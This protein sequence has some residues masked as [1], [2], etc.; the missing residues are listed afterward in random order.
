MRVRARLFV[1][2][3]IGL[4]LASASVQPTFAQAPAPAPAAAAADQPGSDIS[5]D[6]AVRFGRL[7]NGMHY[8]LM[9][10]AA[11][12]G[13]TSVRMR[14]AA[15]SLHERD[16]QRGLAHFIEHLAL[17]ETRNV[18]E[19]E[20]I[21][22]LERAGLSFGADTNA[23]T[24]FEQ[25]VYMLDLPRTDAATVDTALFLMREAVG[26]ATLSP[27]VID[28]ERGVVLSEER[29][30]A[31]P[32]M[33]LAVDELSFLFGND[34]LAR[35]L[36]I[37]A[38]DIISSAQR[39]QFAHFYD[40]YYRPERATLVIVGDFEIDAMEAKIRQRFGDWRGRGAAGPELP[41]IQLGRR[42]VESRVFVEAGLPTRVSLTWAEPRT[43]E[44]DT[45]ATRREGYAA[46]IGMTVLNRR[47][48]RLASG[49]SPP[50]AAA[51]GQI[52]APGERV[53]MYQLIA[54][55]QPNGWRR[56][57]ETIEQEHRRA[58]EHGF[59]E[60]E[61][62][63]EIAVMRST[64]TNAAAGRAS[65]SS[66]TVAD[67]IVQSINSGTIVTSPAIDLALFNE[68]A[69]NLTPAEINAEFRKGFASSNPV[70]HLAA[71]QPVEN[72]QAVLLSAYEA[73]RQLA[74]TPPAV[75]QAQAWPYESFGTA[76]TVAERRELT[77]IGATA[78]RFANGVR[79][80]VK[81]TQF[82]DDE[83]LV[84]TRFGGGSLSLPTDRVSAAWGIPL[85]GFV[86]GGLGRLSFEDLQA[87]LAGKI[88][89]LDAS[90][91]EDAFLLS[92]RTRA[93]DFA[94]QM[95]VLAAYYADP[96]FRAGPWDRLRSLGDTL[97]DQFETSPAGVSGRELDALLRS[98]DRRW[99]FPSR[100]DIAGT[101]VSA[102]RDLVAP[103][104]ASGPIEVIIVGDISVDE[105]IKQTAATFGA[106][107]A[108]AAGTATAAP[109]RF[110]APGAVTLNHGGR[111]DQALGFI[112]WPTTD[113]PS[114]IGRTRGLALLSR[115]FQLRL[116]QQIREEQGA[117]YSPSVASAPSNAAPGYGYF[118]AQIEATPDAMD[119]F[120]RDAQAIARSLR[121][122]PVSADEL[123]RARRPYA[124]LLQRNRATNN[125]WWIANLSGVQTDP[126]Q[127]ASI[128]AGADAVN[129]ITA[130]QLQQLA[131]EYL[132][133]DRAWRLSVL[134]REGT[135][136]VAS[137]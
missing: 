14:I 135:A 98:G 126:R 59:S 56:A 51:L 11:P 91:D 97:H 129:A 45:R 5:V 111:A 50:F 116:T 110:P 19:G 134:P 80:T 27:A 24:G 93:E 30:R 46:L 85:G 133:E 42:P 88:V 87:A 130:A 69:A 35:R 128:R 114:D 83:I 61:I 28:R 90:Q 84:Q 54:I 77:E 23:V 95:K 37:G 60:A 18:P 73:S 16:D 64:L 38:T 137:Q 12:P 40:A 82:R 104:L 106:L 58:I 71:P 66:S 47:L 1:S 67:T 7:S 63:R 113:G 92:G 31:S 21:R 131:R 89:G 78:I 13:G 34:L 68:V 53:D 81:P 43:D 57:L 105:A 86:P 79:L 62:Q 117:A 119:G 44:P 70:I 132:R 55:S 121:E 75:Q 96:A 2:V 36:P 100:Q 8:A 6:P 125:Q 94:L 74:V 136:A 20:F 29:T 108:R 41:Q 3:G 17:N 120:F 39:P 25:T 109:V 65:R 127:L 123:E 49:D 32:N 52:S 122:Q 76:G 99:G 9:R 107:P 4:L 48:E 101:P 102:L 22:I 72:G 103:V 33:R 10:N 112:A 118:A 15:G 26:E 124:E 115:V